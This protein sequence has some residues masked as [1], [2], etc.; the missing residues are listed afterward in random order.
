MVSGE[1]RSFARRSTDPWEYNYLLTHGVKLLISGD[2]HLSL[3]P[4]QM[5]FGDEAID[6]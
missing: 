3:K 6:S 1:G 2:D 5:G 4:G